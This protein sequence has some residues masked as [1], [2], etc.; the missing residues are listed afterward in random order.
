MIAELA[1]DQWTV[2]C[3]TIEKRVDRYET[4]AKLKKKYGGMKT[5]ASS[6]SI[7]ADSLQYPHVSS[8]I[9]PLMEGLREMPSR[10]SEMAIGQGREGRE[11]N[12]SPSLPRALSV[13]V[14]R[15]SYLGF[16]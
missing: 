6:A 15:N 10:S 7:V 3:D 2:T 1:L 12:H 9:E 14:T 8:E 5:K 4:K 11:G 13:S 16:Q